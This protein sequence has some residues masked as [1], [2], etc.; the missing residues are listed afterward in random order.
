ML[1]TISTNFSA[2]QLQRDCPQLAHRI[3]ILINT[4]LQPGEFHDPYALKVRRYTI[5]LN[6]HTQRLDLR[7][8]WDLADGDQPLLT[9]RALL[10]EEPSVDLTEA[11]ITKM[12]ITQ[13]DAVL[14]H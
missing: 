7:S 6:Q 8:A 2:A 3:G 12:L 14:A 9:L 5:V 13:L 10:G 1:K 4:Y 11:T